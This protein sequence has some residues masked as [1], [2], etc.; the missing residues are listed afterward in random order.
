MAPAAPLDL[1][2]FGYARQAYDSALKDL[3]AN[4]RPH[5]PSEAERRHIPACAY[6]TYGDEWVARFLRARAS[7]PSKFDIKKSTDMVIAS[8]AWRK[9]VGADTILDEGPPPHPGIIK[10]NPCGF[11]GYTKNGCCIYIERLGRSELKSAV[12]GYVPFQELVRYK[13]YAQELL[14]RNIWNSPRRLALVVIDTEGVSM[15]HGTRDMI[16]FMQMQGKVDADN[17]P[18][19]MAKCFV[20]NAMKAVSVLWNMV[21]G[22]FD[23]KVREKISFCSGDYQAELLK[24]CDPDQLPDFLHGGTRPSEGGDHWTGDLAHLHATPTHPSHEG[25][26][27]KVDLRGHPLCVAIKAAP[28]TVVRWHYVTERYPVSLVVQEHDPSNPAADRA[29]RRSHERRHSDARGSIDGLVPAGDAIHRD[30]FGEANVRRSGKAIVPA[31]AT[32]LD[33]VWCS[34]GRDGWFSGHHWLRYEAAAEGEPGEPAATTP[35]SANG[36]HPGRHAAPHA[37]G[38][39]P[40]EDADLQTAQDWGHDEYACPGAGSIHPVWK[41]AAARRSSGASPAAR[42][43]A[44]PSP[45]APPP[46][47]AQRSS[48]QGC[49]CCV[50]S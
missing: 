19:I 29:H 35:V 18:E 24:W 4:V 47:P 27:H 12:P 42:S 3:L 8:I 5:L 22:A 30:H 25:L 34:E 2:E 7:P 31:G 17:Y 1:N 21:K 36:G 44:Q 14:C 15:A 9:E 37:L 40:D 11:T 10:A 50:I 6:G 46:E 43:G 28:G 13:V 45:R 16:R 32:G 38:H 23:P 20:I 41:H 33:L 48:K 39:L 49:H 26:S